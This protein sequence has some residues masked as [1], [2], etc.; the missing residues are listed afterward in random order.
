MNGT[1][2][3]HERFLKSWVWVFLIALGAMLGMAGNLHAQLQESAPESDA[4][5]TPAPTVGTPP[6]APVKVTASPATAKPRTM[7]RRALQTPSW[8]YPLL[9]L[10]NGARF[11]GWTHVFVTLPLVASVVALAFAFGPRF[12]RTGFWIRREKHNPRKAEDARFTARTFLSVVLGFCALLSVCNYIFFEEH[13]GF[14]R[15][16]ELNRA[17]EPNYTPEFSHFF[18][19]YEFYHY[20]IGT[21]YAAEVGYTNMYAATLVADDETG[22]KFRSKSG[23]LR[24]LATGDHSLTVKQ[25]LADREK[26]KA[27][28]SE[29]R[30]KQF[31]RDIVWF[32]NLD[33]MPVLR[34]SG[35]LQ[36]KG[37]NSTPVVSM[38]VGGIFSNHFS[39][40]RPWQMM[41]LAMLDP[42]LIT[43]AT[44]LVI[45]TFGGRAAMFMLVLLGTHYVMHWWH[46]K[47]A[48][49][50]TD[51]VMCLIMTVCLVKKERYALAGVL[52]GWAVLSRVFPVVFLFGIGAKIFW[53]LFD[54]ALPGLQKRFP[55]WGLGIAEDTDAGRKQRLTQYGRY[56]TTFIVL[57]G[58]ILLGSLVYWRGIA[59]WQDFA[60]KIRFHNDSISTWRLGFKYI[61]LASFN[62]AIGWTTPFR[63]WTPVCQ[64]KWFETYKGLW[65]S[66]QGGSLL[67]ALIAARGLKPYQ[68]IILGFVPCF[69][70]ASATYYYFIL[71]LV[72]L[73]FFAEEPERLS[74]A[75]G[76]AW[77]YI[78]GIAGY[79]FYD[80]I[81]TAG[82]HWMQREYATYYWIDWMVFVT[83]LWML[84]L[85][86]REGRGRHTANLMT[87]VTAAFGWALYLQWP[88]AGTPTP[89]PLL[90][91]FLYGVLMFGMELYREPLE[92][93]LAKIMENMSRKVLPARFLRP[94][95]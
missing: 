21:K 78:T 81:T 53:E 30:W 25:V 83:V 72:P 91:A 45:W 76:M 36:D 63:D 31:V 85:A 42:L 5:T 19:A 68:S 6:A 4:A 52:T 8:I 7:V 13:L 69:F 28:F 9:P 60:A 75:L 90:F 48:F 87:A 73:L 51:F 89:L 29:E 40:D 23:T 56:F 54:A 61:F 22:M 3:G 71:L 24:N 70:L 41:F 2:I 32:K 35:I 43:I 50:R 18:N 94:T 16:P 93:R 74:R 65:W 77:M 55:H 27:L 62:S 49:V 1:A 46:M 88:L 10:W 95:A 64:D 47:G 82:S 37:Y 34:W 33:Q 92:P 26:Y 15:A 39:P 14:F 80:L 12:Q 58:G 67:L 38:V 17:D 44:G 57:I 66:I 11:G 79:V 86:L 59:L 20:Y 84:A